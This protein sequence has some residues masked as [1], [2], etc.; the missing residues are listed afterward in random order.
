VAECSGKNPGD[1]VCN[2]QTAETRGPDLVSVTNAKTCSGAS[3][4]CQDGTCLC[5]PTSKQCD[6]AGTNGVMTCDSNGSWGTPVSCYGTTPLCS[7]GA[8]VPCPGTGGPTMV[9]LPLNYCIDSTEVTQGQYQNW[10]NTSPSTTGQIS[11]CRWNTSFTPLSSCASSSG[12][13]A[14]NCPQVCVN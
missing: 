13:T 10:L 3:P 2:G 4:V 8:C 11:V 14:A 6:P 9:G 7:A 1:G 5:T 12:C